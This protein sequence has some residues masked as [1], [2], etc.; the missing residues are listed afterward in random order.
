MHIFLTSFNC[1][2]GERNDTSGR[3]ASEVDSG[4]ASVD[5][6]ITS[7]FH[8]VVLPRGTTGNEAEKQLNIYH[9]GHG[10]QSTNISS[11]PCE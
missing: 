6:C 9:A 2:T 5:S 7:V 3:I 8:V 11:L 10:S 1:S 4:I